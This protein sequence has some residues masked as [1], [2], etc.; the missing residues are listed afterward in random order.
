MRAKW[1]LAK[2]CGACHLWVR[3]KPGM[4]VAGIVVVVAAQDHLEFLGLVQLFRDRK[5]SIQNA[6][7]PI[8][9]EEQGQVPAV[10]QCSL[11][12]RDQ[13]CPCATVR[14][15]SLFFQQKSPFLLSFV[16]KLRNFVGSKA[17][18]R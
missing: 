8:H 10:G 4:A 7:K 16:P 18:A 13:P 6:K 5:K 1:Q 2:E 14:L 15:F 9:Q 3:G 17:N 12:D 11:Q